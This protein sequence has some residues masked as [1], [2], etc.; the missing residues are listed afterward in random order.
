[1]KSSIPNLLAFLVLITCLPGVLATPALGEQPE[2]GTFNLH[3]AFANQLGSGIYDVKGNTVQI[4]RL[5][6]SLSLVSLDDHS[7]GLRLILP[8]TLGFFNF[9]IE[10]ILEGIP[11]YLSSL[12]FVPTI[13][14]TF[15]A[16]DNWLLQPFLGA[17]IGKEFSQGEL[18]LI[19][20]LG[21]RS[22]VLFPW[23]K[24]DLPGEHPGLHRLHHG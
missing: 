17:G 8:I 9:R 15:P 6:G 1:M 14:L 18:S 23:N 5:A 13:E 2:D 19:Y 11:E 12:T 16:R 20:A 4:Y 24:Q 22:T 21:V 10:D 3:Y 7:Y